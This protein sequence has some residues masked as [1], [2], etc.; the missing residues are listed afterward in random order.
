[1]EYELWKKQ[2]DESSKAFLWFC[3]YR[4]MGTERSLAKVV[5]KA[6]KQKSY[7]A[8][9]EKWSL[10]YDWVNRCE[11]YDAYLE[12]LKRSAQ[13]DEIL[14][15]ARKHIRIANKIMDIA[16]KRL[17]SLDPSTLSPR[18]I[19][20]YIELAVRIEREALGVASKVEVKSEITIENK[21]S[22]DL[23]KKSQLLLETD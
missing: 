12:S 14:K 21:L 7:R 11:A 15:V 5:H 4:D 6:G 22:E 8:Q 1:M 16:V 19:A 23:I 20:Q 10:R 18:E 9:L 3:M 17:E 13:E 2:G